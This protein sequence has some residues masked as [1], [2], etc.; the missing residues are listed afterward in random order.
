MEKFAMLSLFLLFVALNS[1]SISSSAESGKLATSAASYQCMP[2]GRDCDNDVYDKPGKCPHC[3]MELV[4]KSTV[5]F[6]TIEPFIAVSIR[7]RSS[8][9]GFIGRSDKSKNLKERQIRITEL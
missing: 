2:C 1:Q 5:H 6:K 9:C 3:Q 8:K 4:E 7:G